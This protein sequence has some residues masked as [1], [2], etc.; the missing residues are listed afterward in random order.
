MSDEKKEYLQVEVD[1]K[2]ARELLWIM[3]R[4]PGIT[5]YGSHPGH[6][7]G[8][9]IEFICYYGDDESLALLE[10]YVDNDYTIGGKVKFDR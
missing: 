7:G 2:Y 5:I 9:D 8:S 3:S 10:I 1:R 4:T 6:W